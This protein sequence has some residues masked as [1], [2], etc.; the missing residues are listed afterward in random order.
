MKRFFY[1]I[2][3]PYILLMRGLYLFIKTE[4]TMF[5]AFMLFF[6][7]VHILIIGYGLQVSLLLETVFMIY[8]S[9]GLFTPMCYFESDVVRRRTKPG[10]IQLDETK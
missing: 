7:P 1:Y 3:F 6:V 2:F 4:R 5:Y 8:L 9:A 10:Y